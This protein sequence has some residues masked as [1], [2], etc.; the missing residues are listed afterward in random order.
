MPIRA[1]ADPSRAAR[2]AAP[3]RPRTPPALPL[4]GNELVAPIPDRAI[5]G[6]SARVI[7]NL[8]RAQ[9]TDIDAQYFETVQEHCAPWMRHQVAQWMLEVAE[10]EALT[11]S[12]YPQAMALLDR[13]LSAQSIPTTQLQL[14]AATC[15]LIASK[16][17]ESAALSIASLVFYTDSSI[18]PTQIHEMELIILLKTRWAVLSVTAYDFLHPI[19]HRLRLGV[20]QVH[21]VRSRARFLV[22]ISCLDE[23]L[24]SFRP[25]I[26][27]S[28]CV[29]ISLKGIRMR[30]SRGR[31]GRESGDGASGSDLA[32]LVAR[33]TQLDASQIR[34]CHVTL[35]N[36]ISRFRSTEEEEQNTP[37]QVNQVWF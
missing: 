27:A 2:P 24:L 19:I 20:E 4:A 32:R 31:R 28:S 9:P 7:D 14:L 5:D 10:A 26:I 30:G 17:R 6:D 21:V 34:A 33:R 25:S 8:V 36:C 18:T 1:R 23:S 15:L 11:P 37:Q 12:S 3:S 22:D 16:V 35:Q 13:F 29:V